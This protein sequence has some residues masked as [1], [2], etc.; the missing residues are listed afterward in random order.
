MYSRRERLTN[1]SVKNSKQMISQAR[2]RRPEC[3]QTTQQTSSRKT[4][5]ETAEKAQE[6]MKTSLR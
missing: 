1:N 2:P 6:L 5:Q 3:N 4:S